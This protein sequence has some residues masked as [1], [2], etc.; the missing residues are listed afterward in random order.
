MLAHALQ[1]G[2]AEDLAGSQLE[3]GISAGGPVQGC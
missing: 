3:R 1:P 2:D